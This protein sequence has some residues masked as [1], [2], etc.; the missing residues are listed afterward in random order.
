MDACWSLSAHALDGEDEGDVAHVIERARARAR[1]GAAPKRL[2]S[3]VLVLLVG[4]PTLAVFGAAAVQVGELVYARS[5]IPWGDP[6]FALACVV[7]AV[8]CVPVLVTLHV[9]REAVRRHE[10]HQALARLVADAVPPTVALGF[11]RFTQLRWNMRRFVDVVLSGAAML[12]VAGMLFVPLAGIRARGALAV[13]EENERL[14]PKR[15]APS[16]V[17]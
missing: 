10:L 4:I 6:S 9:L 12:P 17:K 11:L 7:Q 8:V 15:S 16:P 1:E 3:V 14:I 2:A 13:H 5:G